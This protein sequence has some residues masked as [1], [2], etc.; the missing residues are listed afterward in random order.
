MAFFEDDE[1][2]TELAEEEQRRQ[3]RPGLSGPFIRLLLVIAV[4]TVIVVLGGLLIRSWLHSR[5]V[6][7]YEAY[8]TQV[9][10]ILERSDKMGR[11]LSRLLLEPGET[12]RKD[13]QTRLDQYITT[14][15]QLTEEAK[16]LEA[17][18]DLAEAH[19]WFVA[20]MQ[21]RNR[22]LENLK[23]GLLRA[24]EVEDV[25]VSSE[26]ISRAMLLLVLSDVAYEE[27]FVS[28]ASE[29][30]KEQ[31]IGGVTVA[32]TDFITDSSLSSKATIAEILDLMRSSESLQTVHG[33]ALTEVL[34]LPAEKL[35][36]SDGT[37]NLQSTDDLKFVVT[38]ENQGNVNETDVPVELT[39][40]S[41]AS[42]QPQ[43]V[44]VKIPEIKAK[45]SK[46]IT[47]SGV[48]PTD[49]GEKALLQV[50]VG[51]VQDEK[52]QENNVLEAHVIFV[53]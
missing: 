43:I 42:P 37:Y 29:V 8:M 41:P 11:E 12:T 38:V 19:Q 46:K 21:L 15:T 32:S 36:E 10:S 5:E 20:T 9:T 7:S 4:V 13:L 25:E 39:L 40:T 18:S 48:N 49:Y 35:I 27:F 28:R 6:S 53:L 52:I 23:P 31:E 1:S 33:V 30:L 51:P 17:P 50:S 24:L 44:A 16:A 34:A 22:G 45:E 47:I 3:S 26:T 2:F 14:S